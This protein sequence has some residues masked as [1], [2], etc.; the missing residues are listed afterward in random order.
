MRPPI[1][2]LLSSAVG[3]LATPPYKTQNITSRFESISAKCG[4]VTT[5]YFESHTRPP[6]TVPDRRGHLP[7]TRQDVSDVNE[8][9]DLSKTVC[10]ER[11][12]GLIKSFEWGT[13]RDQ[14]RRRFQ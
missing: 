3:V 14:D 10:H 1:T 13:R 9:I 7:P 5:C 6:H 11:L 4:A 8:T 2:N 12:G